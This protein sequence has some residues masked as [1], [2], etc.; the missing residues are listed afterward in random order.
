MNT[1]YMHIKRKSYP[2]GLCKI[3]G[4]NKSDSRIDVQV[5]SF[6]G[7]DEVYNVHK[8]CLHDV[9]WAGFRDIY[10]KETQS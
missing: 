8:S 10:L 6:R 3:C 5:T 7:D 1:P 9:G 2:K 4:K